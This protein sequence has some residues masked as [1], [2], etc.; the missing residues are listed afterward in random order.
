M[1]FKGI[2]ISF[3]VI[4]TLSFSH[5]LI[6][7]SRQVP[8]SQQFRLADRIIRISEPGQLSDSVN[9]WGDVGSSGR[10]LIP[11]GTDL[12]KLLSYSFGPTTLRDGQ[13]QI[14][15]SKMRVE[16][17]IQ[18]YD[19]DNG[20]QIVTNFKYRFEEPFPEG[21]QEFELKNNHTV[22]VRV[23][24]KPSFRDYLG[25]FASTVSAVASTIILLDRLGGR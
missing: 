18:E 5:E 12:T 2:L 17:N 19:R 14:D 23:K 22:T 20:G 10:Y 13:T 15:W 25:V 8:S 11:K 7:Q 4:F 1:T 24:R 6:A 16:I 3:L 9:V 21:M